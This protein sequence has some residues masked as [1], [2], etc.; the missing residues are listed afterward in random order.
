M[1]FPIVQDGKQ[2]KERRTNSGGGDRTGD[3]RV[4]NSPP[5]L[6]LILLLCNSHVGLGSLPLFRPSE[7]P[8]PLTFSD[9]GRTVGAGVREE[10]CEPRRQVYIVTQ[11]RE[12]S[13]F[14]TWSRRVSNLLRI[15][16]ESG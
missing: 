10:T 15:P 5:F 4:L 7:T 8:S 12:R 16:N 1:S 6:G 3:L 11:H 14:G 13:T 9:G 2:W